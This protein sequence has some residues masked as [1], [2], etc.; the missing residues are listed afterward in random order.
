MLNERRSNSFVFVLITIL[1]VLSTTSTAEADL[2]G[3]MDLTLAGGGSVIF[4]SFQFELYHGPIF[5]SGS[6]LFDL[7]LFESN[8]G[9]TYTVSSG[10]DFDGAVAMLTNGIDD[11]ITFNLTIPTNDSWGSI[12]PESYILSFS[13]SSDPTRVDFSGYNINSM[14]FTL[15]RLTFDTPGQNVF[16]DGIFTD[17]DFA[18]SVAFDGTVIPVPAAVLLGIIGLSV[19]GIKLR[20]YA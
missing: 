15:N 12:S 1:S 14:S 16:G 10:T 3:S 6:R 11:D 20:K 4:N 7:T 13:D 9:K 2:I 5:G 19:A 17:F 18:G 8:V